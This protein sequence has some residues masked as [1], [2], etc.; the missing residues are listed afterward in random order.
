MILLQDLVEFV[1]NTVTKLPKSVPSIWS[2]WFLLSLALPPREGLAT[3]E[4]GA[5]LAIVPISK[6]EEMLLTCTGR[7]V[8]N[9]NRKKVFTIATGVEGTV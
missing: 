8:F 7:N 3:A 6:Q 2:T 1:K 9:L 4:G 5:E